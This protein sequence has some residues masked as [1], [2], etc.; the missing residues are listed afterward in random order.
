MSSFKTVEEYVQAKVYRHH[1]PYDGTKSCAIHDDTPAS[2][3]HSS[4][5]QG[6]LELTLFCEG[7]FQLAIKEATQQFEKEK[8]KQLYD[9]QEVAL[10]RYKESDPAHYNN[11]LAL[12]PGFDRQFKVSVGMLHN[13]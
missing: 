7:C 10:I 2:Q 13:L 4:R 8:R 9:Y 11:V 12:F 6:R 5:R 3:V 1:K